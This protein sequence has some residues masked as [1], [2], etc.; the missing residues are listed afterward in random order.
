MYHFA[1]SDDFKW[2]PD[3]STIYHPKITTP[4]DMWSLLHELAHAEL[5][6]TTYDL[7]I[8]L[9]SH[10][11][12]AWHFAAT[13]LAPAYN[14]VIDDDHIQDHLDTYRLWLNQRSTCPNCGQNGLQTKNTYSCVNCRCLWRAND[15]RLC[16]LR[17][18]R[19]QD[20]GQTS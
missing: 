12:D 8:E 5:G 10:E 4:E 6:H 20:Q 17:R 15:A 9:V 13:R 19:L 14:L 16:N 3:T 11:A 7:D 1:L 18:I 2:S